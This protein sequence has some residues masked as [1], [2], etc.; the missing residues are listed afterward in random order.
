MSLDFEITK[1]S[2]VDGVFF[3]T[4][5]LFE[6]SRGSIWT[7]FL[8]K[9]LSDL[10]PCPL[11]FNHDKFSTS[12]LDV[13]RGIHYD[14]KS[15][16]I[17]SC[18]A[19]QVFQVAVDMRLNSPSYLQHDWLYIDASTPK[20]VLLPPGVG[21]AFCATSDQAVYHYKLAYEGSYVDANDQQTVRWDDPMLKIMWPTKNPILSSRDSSCEFMAQ[22]D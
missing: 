16:K 4:P 1:S 20:L 12:Q 22:S 8:Q 9:T 5:S 6:D 14:F 2:K 13:L 15:W 18:V 3:V 10:L 11:N 7:S 21:N 17:V 19:G